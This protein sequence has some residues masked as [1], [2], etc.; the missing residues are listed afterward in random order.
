MSIAKQFEVS[1]ATVANIFK[2]RAYEQTSTPELLERCREITENR[3][4]SLPRTPH[5]TDSLIA[6]I[7]DRIKVSG[8]HLIWT[9]GVNGPHRSPIVKHHQERLQVRRVLHGYFNGVELGK[10]RMYC[11]CSESSCVNPQHMEAAIR[12]SGFR[13]EKV[14]VSK[15][16]EVEVLAILQTYAE[17]ETGTL[18]LA[19]RYGVDH[20]TISKIIK[21]E[22]WKHIATPELLVKCG[23]VLDQNKRGQK[24]GFA[25]GRKLSNELVLE[26]RELYWNR[27]CSQAVLARRY[28]V[29]KNSVGVITKRETWVHLPLVGNEPASDKAAPHRKR[30]KAAGSRRRGA[31]GRFT[32]ADILSQLEAQHGRCYWCHKPLDDTPEIDHIFPIVPRDESTQPGTN[33]PNNICIAHMWC[34]RSKSNKQPWEAFGRLF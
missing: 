3:V 19:K 7:Y 22:N 25:A 12:T 23:Q 8:D 27:V 13:G 24:T 15:L 26:I 30:V 6:A 14:T 16:T 18:A 5:I 21:G 34:N 29:S 33:Y 31:E 1:A 9:G 17:G 32:H 4:A 10:T 11:N 28:G 20:N 2:G